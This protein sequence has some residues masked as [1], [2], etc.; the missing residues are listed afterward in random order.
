MSEAAVFVPELPM[1]LSW[2]APLANFGLIGGVSG[3]FLLD[4]GV[5]GTGEQRTL[6]GDME[7]GSGLLG[8]LSELSVDCSELE[9]AMAPSDLCS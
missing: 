5:R 2:L 7:Q 3:S 8:G 1:F 9:A 4:T 6:A